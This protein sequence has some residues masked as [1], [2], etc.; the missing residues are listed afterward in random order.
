MIHLKPVAICFM[1]LPGVLAGGSVPRH[2]IHLQP[3]AAVVEMRV[4]GMER[5]TTAAGDLGRCPA[6]SAP[7]SPVDIAFPFDLAELTPPG[8][9]RLDAL[10]GWLVCNPD[11][12][13]SLVAEGDHHRPQGADLD[14]AEQRAQS[15][16]T[17]LSLRG[18]DAHRIALEQ[19]L[20]KADVE[21]RAPLEILARGRGW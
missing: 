3:S 21:L 12:R 6:R 18:V 15:V 19:R 13:V 5:R 1:A 2:A 14:L 11:V 7:A 4:R 9:T 20:A 16:R 17:Y 8:L 10:S